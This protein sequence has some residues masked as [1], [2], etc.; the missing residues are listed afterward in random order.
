MENQE[1]H[2]QNNKWKWL[3]VMCHRGEP[4]IHANQLKS[5]NELSIQQ[6]E[7]SRYTCFILQFLE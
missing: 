7:L 5:V 4:T 1:K 6:G 2:S 3:Q